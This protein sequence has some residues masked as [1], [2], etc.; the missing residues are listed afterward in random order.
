MTRSESPL[1]LYLGTVRRNLAIVLLLP[2]TA[3]VVA[4]FVANTQEPVYRADMKLVVGQGGGLGATGST[5]NEAFN[6]TMSSLLDSDIV[7]REVSAHPQVTFPL[8]PQQFLDGLTITSRPESAVLDVSFDAG[9]PEQAQAVLRAVGDVF[10]DVVE[11]RLNAPGQG[12]TPESVVSVRVFDP[13]IGQADQVAP[14]P[15]RTAVIAGA[16]GLLVAMMLAFARDSL[17]RREP[18]GPPPPDRMGADDDDA[19]RA[20]DFDV[21]LR[22]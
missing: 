10:P 22:R 4:Y 18:D 3:A 17:R 6:Q 15:L 5:S 21:A 20:P 2:L 7:A 19:A 16:V 8:S 12:V 1:S 13:P 14:A 9:S 11:R